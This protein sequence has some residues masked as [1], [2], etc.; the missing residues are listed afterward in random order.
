MWHEIT[1]HSKNSPNIFGGKK[2]VVRENHDGDD[3]SLLPSGSDAVKFGMCQ[4]VSH[5]VTERLSMYLWYCFT[6]HRMD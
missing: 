6:L 5:S 3:I 1:S 2:N 4:A